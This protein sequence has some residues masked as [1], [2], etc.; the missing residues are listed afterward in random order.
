MIS[1][2]INL[3]AGL[4]VFLIGF[5]LLSDNMEKLAS[6]SL[7]KM[8]GKTAKSKA[9]GVGIGAVST[10]IVQSS[11]VTTVMVVGFVNAGLMTLSQ[12]TSVIMGA[13]IGSTI[14]A[15]IS[16]LGSFDF[17]EYAMT[18]SA[19]GIFIDM[20]AKKEH[21]KSAGV[22][23]AGLG[24]VFVG[25]QMMSGAMDG[26]KDSPT[27]VNVIRSVENPFVLLFLGIAITAALQSSG[28]VTA[29]IISMVASGMILGDNALFVVLG[30]NIGTCVTALLASFGAG[31]NAKRACAIH[32]LFNIFGALLFF[33]LLVLWNWCFGASFLEMTFA[34][35]FSA[36][37]TQIAMFH[38]FFN[39]VCT[40]LFLPLTNMFVKLS[41]VIVPEGKAAE[42][43]PIVPMDR[44]LI[45][46]PSI[47]LDQLCK[48]AVLMADSAV[49]NIRLAMDGYLGR[50]ESGTEEILKRNELLAR[51]YKKMTDYL[52]QI[53]GQ[54]ISISDEKLITNLHHNLGDIVRISELADNV[55]KY[56][57]KEIAQNLVF[58]P[59]V[60]EQVRAMTD[61]LLSL[62]DVTRKTLAERTTA[63]LDRVDALE[64]EVD[65]MRKK[66]IDDH[67]ERMNNGQCKAENSSVFINLVSNL[68]RAGDHLSYIAHSGE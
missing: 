61:K 58:S 53:S 19:I 40:L 47:A 14:T 43:V 26:F 38:T 4:G 37:S 8:F 62:Y 20:V 52:I 21:V 3:L 42:K 50:D 66:L 64:D 27:I 44:R 32:F 39:T 12:A 22:A 16:A 5:R 9:A 65:G 17:V 46:T 30:S 6:G 63:Y 45:K 31:R 41:G 11:S 48:E 68:E 15:Q 28:A 57:R 1:A 59:G 33:I 24:L 54:D 60:N 23:L 25:L 67:I 7:K 55:T 49:D 36:P 56:T 10:A 34:R 29:I 51:Q 18:L 13:N 35:I 2:I